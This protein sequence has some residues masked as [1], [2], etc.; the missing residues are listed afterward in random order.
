MNGIE[1]EIDPEAKEYVITSTKEDMGFQV[2][3]AKFETVTTYGISQVEDYYKSLVEADDQ[4]LNIYDADAAKEV[5]EGQWFD[6][7]VSEKVLEYTTEETG[8]LAKITFKDGTSVKEKL[9]KIDEVVAEAKKAIDDTYAAVL[10]KNK[11]SAYSKIKTEQ[12]NVSTSYG[13]EFKAA[14]RTALL[15]AHKTAIE[16]C[17]TL[18]ALTKLVNT[19][20]S[21][22][23]TEGAK[24][25]DAGSLNTLYT[26]KSAAF[27]LVKDQLTK[28]LEAESS[29]SNKNSPEYKETVAGLQAWGISVDK[30]PSEVAQSYYDQISA[31]ESL[32]VYESGTNKDKTVLG[33]TGAK[34]VKDSLQDLKD[35]LVDA[36][37]KSYRSEIANSVKV[38]DETVKTTL[39][40][41]VVRTK[42]EWLAKVGSTN[43]T[44]GE[45]YEDR[46]DTLDMYYGTAWPVEGEDATKNS[47]SLVGALEAALNGSQG[48]VLLQQERLANAKASVKALLQSQHDSI[49]AVDTVYADAQSYKYVE[50]ATGGYVYT[51]IKHNKL[52]NDGTIDNFI[53]KDENN[54][55]GA[56]EADSGYKSKF[57]NSEYSVSA[58]LSDLTKENGGLMDKKQYASV[59]SVLDF[60]TLHLNDLGKVY[61]DAALEL[62]ATLRTDL[63]DKEFVS[64]GFVDYVYALNYYDYNTGK[65]T[66]TFQEI[67]D[68]ADTM[69]A[70][71][72]ILGILN[73]NLVAWFD[74]ATEGTKY[75][76][77]EADYA[78]N[79]EV[80]KINSWFGVGQLVGT[81]GEVGK[82]CDTNNTDLNDKIGFKQMGTS[83]GKYS[84][85]RAAIEDL[86]TAVILGQAGEA[87]VNATTSIEGL[88]NLYDQEVSAY[89]ENAKELLEGYISS[90]NLASLDVEKKLQVED[91]RELYLAILG[92]HYTTVKGTG[93]LATFTDEEYK[94]LSESDLKKYN[95]FDHKYVA[96]TLSSCDQWLTDAKTAIATIIG[97]I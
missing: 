63:A 81:A 95:D 3:G 47:Y 89:K 75:V 50:D 79:N 14:D 33:V 83:V 2:T 26:L 37:V 4:L 29:L 65:V 61:N 16:N 73:S 76:D 85:F 48:S 36:I 71:E 19:K 77:G 12:A 28:T 54:M 59:Q 22:T 31:A 66:K 60:K 5:K 93:A 62:A 74:S 82:D 18:S 20:I 1:I 56:V 86:I 57:V 43:T 35:A 45:N 11:A 30:L 34:A 78:S 68:L 58:K 91:A 80:T 27:K 10:K 55:E 52:G 64:G 21:N 7:T 97:T 41:L 87:E 23:T 49:L 40:S 44:T 24:K 90:I 32:E 69:K 96:L 53:F 51:E 72:T 9:E 25:A 17:T 15:A 8:K 84:S 38:T 70:S 42:D 46:K 13:T 88:N 67:Y 92:T 39:D 6:E 94:A